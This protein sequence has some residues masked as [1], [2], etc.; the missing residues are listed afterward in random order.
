MSEILLPDFLIFIFILFYFIF[1]DLQIEDGQI[2]VSVSVVRMRSDGVV[3]TTFGFFDGRFLVSV[4]Q[5][6]G[7]GQQDRA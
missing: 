3:E 1:G 7:S 4:V 5:L 6:V 2:V